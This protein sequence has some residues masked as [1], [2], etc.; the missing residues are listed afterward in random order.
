MSQK[1]T[2]TDAYMAWLEWR[3]DLALM[4]ARKLDQKLLG[5]GQ[6]DHK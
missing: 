3:M 4:L 1:N 6:R 2:P 5:P